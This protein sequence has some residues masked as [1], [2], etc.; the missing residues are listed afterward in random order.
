[1]CEFGF[2]YWQPCWHTVEVMIGQPCAACKYTRT[3]PDADVD[4]DT[5]PDRHNAGTY[6]RGFADCPQCEE[7]QER[8]MELAAET[9]TAGNSPISRESPESPGGSQEDEGCSVSSSVVAA[10]GSR[11]IFLIPQPT[12]YA[13]E[14]NAAAQQWLDRAMVEEGCP[15]RCG[16]RE[17]GHEAD[18]FEHSE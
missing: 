10:W 1:M 3:G 11:P 6:R 2:S 14:Q 4:P 17:W 7:Y 8:D 5:C 15:S 18:G 16:C 13:V 9:A 12:G